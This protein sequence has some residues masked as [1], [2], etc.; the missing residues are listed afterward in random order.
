LAIEDQP[1]S[2]ASSFLKEVRVLEVPDG[3]GEKTKLE[4]HIELEGGVLEGAEEGFPKVFD[5][6]VN[7][8][9]EDEEGNPRVGPRSFRFVE[10]AVE[11]APVQKAKNPLPQL[12]GKAASSAAASSDFDFDVWYKEKKEDLAKPIGLLRVR[13]PR[14]RSPTRPR[15]GWIPT[16][17]W[18]K[19]SCRR[20]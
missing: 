10:R 2:G 16:W 17:S 9:S 14:A 8:P 15:Q 18:V 6:V 5:A 1:S 12:K 11:E 19:T 20:H 3:E 13:R 4:V 7:S